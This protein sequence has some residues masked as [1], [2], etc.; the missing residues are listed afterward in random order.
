M[1]GPYLLMRQPLLM[2]EFMK[3]IRSM[4]EIMNRYQPGEMAIENVFFAKNV[5]S[6]LKLGHARGAALVAAVVAASR[7]LNI[8]PLR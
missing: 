5:K 4:T 2:K 1:Q 3:F 7:Y 8:L 6:S